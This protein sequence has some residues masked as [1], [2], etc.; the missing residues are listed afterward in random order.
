MNLKIMHIGEYVKGGV[1]TYLQEVVKYQNENREVL[2]LKVM[3]S[4][5]NSDK[6]FSM[7][8]EDIEAYPYERNIKSIIKA[9]FY[10][11]KNIKEHKPDII[12]IHSTFAGFFVRVPLLFQKKRYKV[13]YCSH[14]W[15]FCMETSAL[16]KKVYEIVERVLATRTDKII[17]ISSSE[18]E[19]ALKRGLSYEKCELIHNGIS[20]DLH[21][22]DIEY[23]I[24]PSK[25]NLL[26]VGR[27][28]RQKGL[29]ILLKF[30]ESYQNHNIKLHIIG[31][32][33]LNN[34][35]IKIP[36]NVVS[37]GW[38]NHEHIDSYYKLFD[39]IIIPSRWE[40][41]GLVAIEA[42]KNK[43]AIIVS[44]RGALPELANT[45]NGYVFDL[46][47]LD[48]LKELLDNL[49]KEE[50]IVKGL[51][52]FNEFEKKYTSKKMNTEIIKLY[53]NIL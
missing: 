3:L 48:T 9:M 36:S 17:N 34:D 25:I 12:H 6:N 23:R 19:E 22:G 2:N 24:D 29:D 46:N 39:A 37:I 5:T 45:S 28:D 52:G 32:S 41:F 4:D 11:N 8:K 38:I 30:F 1:A 33:I 43:K 13:V 53:K 7:N 40:G 35:D 18:H 15:A 42:M 26:F 44:N 27:F 16:K 21:E 49:N 10:V 31:E 14:G 50:L 20:T 51:N 47:N